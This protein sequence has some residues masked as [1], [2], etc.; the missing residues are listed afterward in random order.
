M[1][2]IRLSRD[3]ERDVDDIIVHY[4]KFS[5][6]TANRVLDDIKEVFAQLAEFPE[7]GPRLAVAELRKAVSPKYRFVIL[8]QYD[9]NSV[10]VSQVYRH[11]N[12]EF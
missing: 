6:D 9:G 8:Y 2:N 10:E 4:S 5:D 3:A 7:S 12:R 11:Q 1:T